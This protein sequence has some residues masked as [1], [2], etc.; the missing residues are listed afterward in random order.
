MSAD[1]GLLGEWAPPWATCLVPGA[2]MS[3]WIAAPPLPSGNRIP[4]YILRI[5]LEDGWLSVAER[6]LGDRLPARCPELHVNG[7]GSFCLARWVHSGR[8]PDGVRAF[9][10]SLGEY[11][12]N[13]H[14]AARHRYWPVGRWL[15][16]GPA[17]ANAQAVAE[18]AAAGAGLSN[19]YAAWL[20]GGEGWISRYFPEGGR[21]L[22]LLGNDPCPEACDGCA[23]QPNAMRD[24]PKRPAI[25]RMLVA[26][27][28][29]RRAQTAHFAYLRA[30]GVTCC[31]RVD[32]CELARMEAA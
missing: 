16:H 20:E 6:R 3:E 17:A 10:Q 8:R 11:L 7:G 5:T 1:C 14:H 32:G 29:R 27:A 24:C 26:E 31:G 28:E 18:E 12:V 22:P 4:A 9:W 23:G 13:Q 15:S 30:E 25:K 2:A 19:V 21:P